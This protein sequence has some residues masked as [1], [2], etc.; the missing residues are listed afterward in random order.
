MPFGFLQIFGVALAIAIIAL[1]TRENVLARPLSLIGTIMSF[2]VYYPAGLY[3]KCLL[4]CIYIV[5]NIYG[6]YQWLY[7]GKNKT[8]LQ[9]S[10]S[11]A[12]VIVVGVVLGLL[13]TGGLGKLLT[14][15]SNAE[16]AYWDSL[17]TVVCLVA[18]WMLVRKKLETW[19]VWTLADMLYTVVCYYKGLYLFSGLHA[20]YIILAINGY[21]TWRQSYQRQ[22]G[23]VPVSSED[24]MIG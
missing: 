22:T 1:D 11:K 20:F 15:Y 19:I 21:R 16:L 24:G 9:V 10:K 2:F 5:L 14:R 23:P 4:N 13:A 17:H 6:W 7:G 18:Q 3:A 8:P 12:S